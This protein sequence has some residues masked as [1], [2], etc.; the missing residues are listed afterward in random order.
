MRR[1]D[2][3][4]G[5]AGAAVWPPAA[6]A[7][8]P[9]KPVIA[10]LTNATFEGWE[11]HVRVFSQALREAGFVDGRNV[12]IEFHQAEGDADRLSALTAGLVRR[13]IDVIVANGNAPVVA[14][15]ATSTIPIVVLTGANPVERGTISSLNAPGGNLTGVTGLGDSL[16]PKR[17]ELLHEI[18]PAATDIGVLVNPPN[19]S[20]G[21]Q[22]RD[23]EAAARTLRLRL[24]VVNA[25]TQEDF[26]TVFESLVRLKVG[27]LVIS[28]APIFNNN[29]GRLGALATRHAIPA[30]YSQRDF[31]AGGG[32]MSFSADL[33]DVYR[34][35]GLY[36]GRILKGE[37]PAD[38]P[39]QQ[40]TKF[41]FILN[42]KTAKMLGL[43][44]P[45][46]LRARADEVIE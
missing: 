24:H 27:G 3:I 15:A 8:Q 34:W 4:T 25:T 35:L 19:V 43:T 20:N 29:L 40:A 38:L 30:I 42:L 5:L 31:A 18:A 10:F 17:L 6:W 39:F 11:D 37:K 36:A 16:G 45:L 9:A 26:S 41:Q 21:L 32:L 13:R 46:S 28:V 7:Q 44:V 1:R 12:A 33:K 2:F 14:A 23:L 22:L